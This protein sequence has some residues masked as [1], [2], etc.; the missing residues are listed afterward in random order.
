MMSNLVL[1]TKPK[2]S[3]TELYYFILKIKDY[4]PALYEDIKSRVGIP[5]MIT[6]SLF[7]FSDLQCTNIYKVIKVCKAYPTTISEK[8]KCLPCKYQYGYCMR[9]YFGFQMLNWI[10]DSFIKNNYI[11]ILDE[12]EEEKYNLKKSREIKDI[13]TTKKD[14]Y[15][16]DYLK[17]SK[18]YSISLL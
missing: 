10:Y 14:T 11:K 13:I 6:G 1:N 18:L 3:V 9:N 8:K 4:E 2:F 15:W 16:E 5:L 12:I 17:K 7:K